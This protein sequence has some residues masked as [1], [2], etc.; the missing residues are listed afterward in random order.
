MHR[1]NFITAALASAGA[2]LWPWRAV[3]TPTKSELSIKLSQLWAPE[4]IIDL[5]RWREQYKCRRLFVNG[6]DVTARTRMSYVDPKCGWAVCYVPNDKP[7]SQFKPTANGQV[8]W[9]T[10]YGTVEIR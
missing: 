6:V 10:L 9:E 3:A 8:E 5:R 4:K 1:R 7:F 2:A